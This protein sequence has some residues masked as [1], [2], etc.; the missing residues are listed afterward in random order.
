MMN[1]CRCSLIVF[2][3]SFFA[4]FYFLCGDEAFYFFYAR[5]KFTYAHMS[6]PEAM[7]VVVCG[8]LT[9]LLLV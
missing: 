8:Y 4:L 2:I 5:I 7:R 3:A 9:I 1:I 6:D